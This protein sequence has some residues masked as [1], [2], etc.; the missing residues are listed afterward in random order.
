M[1]TLG[2][3]RVRQVA[4]SV[5][6]LWGLLVLACG[7]PQPPAPPA[8]DLVERA[9]TR[10]AQL[11]S[12]RFLLDV[13][14]GA[15]LLGPSLEV[16]HAEGEVAR[17]DRLHVR[18]SVRMGGVVVETDMVHVDGQSV[19][20][21]PF[22]LKWES[23]G[24]GLAPVPILDPDRG[25][26]RLVRSVVDPE[27]EASETLDGAATWRVRG[28]IPNQA[29]TNLL[30]GTPLDGQAAA[31]AWVS[32]DGLVHRLTLT[33]PIVDGESADTVR[34]LDFSKFDA[35]TVMDLPVPGSS[36]NP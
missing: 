19:L 2:A 10:T 29:V 20:V 22:S 34:R 32:D 24:G 4:T 36:I 1:N 30:G 13:T 11:Q 3:P 27:V 14:K 15:V 6:A 7:A 9:A 18:A 25:V 23:L 21:N 17:P 33:G 8:A 16:T 35:A 31:V 26:S 5:L 28:Q 12:V